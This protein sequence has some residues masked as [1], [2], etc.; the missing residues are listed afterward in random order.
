[1]GAALRRL[2]AQAEEIEAEFGQ[3][4]SAATRVEEAQATREVHAGRQLLGVLEQVGERSPLLCNPAHGP[5]SWRPLPLD[6]RSA[7]CHA[8]AP[9]RSPLPSPPLLHLPRLPLGRSVWR[10]R[11]LRGA[12][13][14]ARLMRLTAGS[15]QPTRAAEGALSTVRALR[16]CP[17]AA[18]ST[19]SP[20]P[21]PPRRQRA[22]RLSLPP[23]S[24]PP[25]P[26]LSPK[27]RLASR[28]PSPPPPPTLPPTPPM[29]RAPPPSRSRRRGQSM[30]GAPPC[31]TSQRP[32]APSCRCR[33]TAA[34]ADAPSRPAA[35]ADAAIR[36]R[37]AAQRRAARRHSGAA[38]QTRPP[39]ARPMAGQVQGRV[40]PRAR[41][42]PEAAA[43]RRVR[44]AERRVRRRRRQWRARMCRRAARGRQVLS[45]SPRT[46][47]S[48]L[49]T[50]PR[51][52][53][54]HAAA[55]PLP[56]AAQPCRALS[57]HSSSK[58]AA[59]SIGMG[60]L[61]PWVATA[62]PSAPASTPSLGPPAPARSA[63]SRKQ[64]SAQVSVPWA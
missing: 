36:L 1:M 16:H 27:C 40:V 24:P 9:S 64:K 4:S 59:G 62:A 37:A 8:H 35:A 11:T 3:V 53:R 55:T 41:P 12:T 5:C 39:E 60:R 26:P 31:R 28:P 44:H 61:A 47:R 30:G 54:I 25:S 45:P 50:A 43:Q 2:E 42:R 20:P 38:C 52:D 46:V 10:A 14:R 21:P 51:G 34:A 63:P 13:R 29:P 23:P 17:R 33:P 15:P 7:A 22:P 58:G 48:A 18:S 49:G 19:A 6:S 32:H 56:A 57:A